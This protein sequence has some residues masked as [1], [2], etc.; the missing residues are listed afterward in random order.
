MPKYIFQSEIDSSN[1]FL[2]DMEGIQRTAPDYLPC[3]Q[4]DIDHC[5]LIIH[6]EISRFIS[7]NK[8]RR[9]LNI[10]HSYI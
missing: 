9:E 3:L 8:R 1:V 10:S 7:D 6:E 5:E 4:P 2:L